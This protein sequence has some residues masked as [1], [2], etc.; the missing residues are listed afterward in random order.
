MPRALAGLMAAVVWFAALTSCASRHADSSAGVLTLR[1][2]FGPAIGPEVI[3]GRAE[4]LRAHDPIVLLVGDQTLV[5]IDPSARAVRR[6]AIQIP[7]GSTCW[8]LARLRDGSLWTLKGRRALVHVLETGEIEREIPL[9]ESQFGLFGQGD[10]LLYQPADFIAPAPALFAGRPGDPQRVAWS[11]L[12]TRPFALSRTSV[13]ALNFVSCGTSLRAERPCWFPD[14]PAIYL[15]DEAGA[16]RRL[17]LAGLYRVSPEVLLTSDNPAR[18][19]RDAYVDS[20][21]TIWV[22]STGAPP[23][24]SPD[25]LGGWVLARYGSGGEPRGAWRLSEPVRLI[26]RAESGRALVLTGAGM[27][28][29]AIP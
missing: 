17:E 10:Q 6:R 9:S 14:E 11:S 15:V 12:R 22:L 5:T 13:A 16:S 18:P 20:G 2:L 4:D 19:V 28:A 29:E 24:P 21:G 8:G 3:A 26:L 27:V 25:V 23:S 1:P 7:A